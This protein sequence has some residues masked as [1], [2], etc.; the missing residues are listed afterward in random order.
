MKIVFN[1]WLIPFLYQFS[2][3]TS[4]ITALV[5]PTASLLRHPHAQRFARRTNITHHIFALTANS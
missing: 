3:S 5:Q 4:K 1:T 2:T